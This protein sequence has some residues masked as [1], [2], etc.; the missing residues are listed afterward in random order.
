MIGPAV[1]G[2]PTPPGLDSWPRH[3][4]SFNTDV[5]GGA[6]RPSSFGETPTGTPLGSLWPSIAG[7]LPPPM[8]TPRVRWQ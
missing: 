8:R 6:S 5:H 3:N 7:E 2:F 1:S 4:I